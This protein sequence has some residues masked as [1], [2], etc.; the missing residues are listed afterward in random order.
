MGTTILY[1]IFTDLFLMNGKRV[2]RN[3]YD[4][5]RTPSE[6]QLPTIILLSKI[7]KNPNNWGFTEI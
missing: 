2:I 1:E 4:D 3:I 5:I 6:G 7:V